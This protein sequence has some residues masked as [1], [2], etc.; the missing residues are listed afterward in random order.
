MGWY[1]GDNRHA[2]IQ[3]LTSSTEWVHQSRLLTRD[4]TNLALQKKLQQTHRA[5][6]G[7]DKDPASHRAK[8]KD[9]T[10]DREKERDR[11][12]RFPRKELRVKQPKPKE[13]D[14][15]E[16]DYQPPLR[17]KQELKIPIPEVLKVILVDDW[18]AVTR[19]GQL[20]SLPRSPCVDDI[21]TEFKEYVLELPEADAPSDIEERLPTVLIG[22]KQY[23]DACV[24][25]HQFSDVRLL[26]G[27]PSSAVGAN[28]LYRFERAQYADI[29]RRFIESPDLPPEQR[30]FESQ[31]YGAEHL[32]RLIGRCSCVIGLEA[33][34]TMLVVSL[35]AQ[36]AAA[37]MELVDINTIRDYSSLLLQ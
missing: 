10:K 24:H 17:R 22:F 18:E 36:M 4:E 27:P 33:P 14:Y 34:L 15:D 5:A 32:V 1:A 12:P 2:H 25:Q 20:V 29:R 9:P 19:H 16:I 21:L 23:F 11:E 31:I 3:V 8:E 6:L 30:K 7:K 35:P 28:L 13:E 26:I 37:K